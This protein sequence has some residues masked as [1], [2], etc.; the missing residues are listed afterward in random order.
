MSQA[1]MR[2]PFALTLILPLL[3][4][5]RGPRHRLQLSQGRGAVR[6]VIVHCTRKVLDM[7]ACSSRWEAQRSDGRSE[8]HGGRGVAETI[9]KRAEN[10]SSGG[11]MDPRGQAMPNRSRTAAPT[12]LCAKTNGVA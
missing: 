9:E 1:S 6:G 11:R 12:S 3:R 5:H 4:K 7:P 8:A 2:L 10:S